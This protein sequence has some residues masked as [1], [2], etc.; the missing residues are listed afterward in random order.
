MRKNSAPDAIKNNENNDLETAAAE[1]PAPLDAVAGLLAD[2]RLR[3]EVGRAQKRD[4]NKRNRQASRETKIAATPGK[5][6]C[7]VIDPPW[8][9]EKIER[10]VRP[11]QV[12]FEYPEGRASGC[13]YRPSASAICASD[14]PVTRGQP[15]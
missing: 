12:G 11:N 3:M 14:T 8:P 4:E 7:V 9:M 13:E 15:R 10:D 6:G 2:E 5:Y 1:N